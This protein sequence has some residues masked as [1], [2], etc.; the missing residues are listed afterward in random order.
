MTGE[1]QYIPFIISRLLGG[2]TGSAGSS[3]GLLS[4]LLRIFIS[5]YTI[6]MKEI[7]GSEWI[8]EMFFLHDRGKAMTLFQVSMMFGTIASSTLS[9]FIVQSVS[10]TVQFWYNVGIEGLVAVGIFL[11]VDETRWPRQPDDEPAVTFKSPIKRKLATYIFVTKIVRNPRLKLETVIR[12]IV[13]MFNPVFILV[14][15][16]VFI[17]FAW[18]VTANTFLSIYLQTP[19]IAGGYGFTAQQNAW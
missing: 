10:W 8:L 4:Y 17:V 3:C 11:F 13:L 1:D 14:G 5:N 12:P 18:G 6:L 19:V 9:G 15:L 2:L 7:V 16:F